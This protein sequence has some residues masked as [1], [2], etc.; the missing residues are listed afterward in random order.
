MSLDIRLFTT[1]FSMLLQKTT[2]ATGRI[3]VTPLY[4]SWWTSSLFYPYSTTGCF[5]I[6]ILEKTLESPL[7]SEGIKPVNPKG[8]Q[9]WIFTGRTDA[10][11]E[12]PKLW[13]LDVKSQLTGKAPDAGKDWKILRFL[14]IW[15]QIR[16]MFC[17]SFITFLVKSFLETMISYSPS[18]SLSTCNVFV[19]NWVICSI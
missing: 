19:R 10:E 5:Q 18:L 8:T 1:S 13:L 11:V 4:Q 15:I 14:W 16:P 7:D 17:D 3:V 12:T 9:P 2:V 6:V